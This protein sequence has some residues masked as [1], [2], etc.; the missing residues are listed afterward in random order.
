MP[1]PT[2][3]MQL[4]H[5]ALAGFCTST[6]MI[7]RMWQ[8]AVHPAQVRPGSVAASLTGYSC[9]KRSSGVDRRQGQKAAV[10]AGIEDADCCLLVICLLGEED[11]IYVGLRI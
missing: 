3:T 8:Q 7:G 6:S 5:V 2:P 10:V 11:V 4:T 1:Q 9:T